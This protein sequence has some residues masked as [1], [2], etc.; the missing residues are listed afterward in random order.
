MPDKTSLEKQKVHINY[1]WD[2][3]RKRKIHIQVT[4]M[5]KEPTSIDAF[6]YR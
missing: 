2:K 1:N 5:L 3:K 4:K 6:L